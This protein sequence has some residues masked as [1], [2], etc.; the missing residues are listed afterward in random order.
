MISSL[1]VANSDGVTWNVY[2]RLQIGSR[3]G[4]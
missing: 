1:S 2:R 4:F 3:F